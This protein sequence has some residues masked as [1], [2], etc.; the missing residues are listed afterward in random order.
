LGDLLERLGNIPPRRVVLDP[1]PGK[2]TEEDLLRLMRRTD[3]LYELVEGTLVEKAM[4]FKEGMLAG[5]LIRLFGRFLD[6]HDLG[7]V[8]GADTTMRLMPHLVRMPDVAV[9]RWEKLPGRQLPT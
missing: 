9:I 4:G 1:S 8:G 7:D 2:A 5:W 6:A 3:R